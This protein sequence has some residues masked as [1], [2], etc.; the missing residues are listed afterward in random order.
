MSHQKSG[1]PLVDRPEVAQ[2]LAVSERWVLRSV[3]EKRLPYVKLGR[4]VRFDLDAVDE[5]LV[6]QSR[7]G[8]A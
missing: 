7:G 5:W 1:R 2:Y 3:A 6:G 8:V 4:L